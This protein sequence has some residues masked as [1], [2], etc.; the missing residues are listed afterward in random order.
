M[1]IYISGEGISKDP[2]NTARILL[3]VEKRGAMV[4]SGWLLFGEVI[5]VRPKGAGAALKLCFDAN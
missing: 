5:C 2:E 1:E 3:N 4:S